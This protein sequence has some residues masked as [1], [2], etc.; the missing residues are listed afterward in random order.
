MSTLYHW[1]TAQILGR[2]E[3]VQSKWWIVVDCTKAGIADPAMLEGRCV[4]VKGQRRRLG[5]MAANTRPGAA[6]FRPWEIRD[7]QAEG[8]I[9]EALRAFYMVIDPQERER[10]IYRIRLMLK[11]SA[12]RARMWR[13]TDAA[14]PS[15]TGWQRWACEA[16]DAV[17]LT[18][19]ATGEWP[20]PCNQMEYIHP[21]GL[22]QVFNM[23]S[24]H[25]GGKYAE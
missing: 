15:L 4:T 6:Y 12:A 5:R 8:A 19:A 7:Y 18:Q 20:L 11:D 2:W 21:A 22:G 3:Q 17:L 9:A 23:F 10:E 1:E 24:W 16:L 14:A 13:P 25:R